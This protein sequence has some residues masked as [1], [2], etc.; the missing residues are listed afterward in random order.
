MA[1]LILTQPGLPYYH[2][3]VVSTDAGRAEGYLH[4]LTDAYHNRLSV[5]YDRHGR[6]SALE[7]QQQQA[8]RFYYLDQPVGERHWWNALDTPDTVPLLARVE[9]QR[10]AVNADDSG[11]ETR[12][13]PLMRYH[14]NDRCQLIAAENALGEQETYRY[15]DQHVIQER[16]LAGGACF[17]WQWERQG[18]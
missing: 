3:H 2:F 11:Y 7:G 4:A 16:R 9:L 12:R 10:M 15:D 6:L 8:L 17:T 1:E 18:L 13:F 5:R 14:Y